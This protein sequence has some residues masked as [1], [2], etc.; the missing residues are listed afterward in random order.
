MLQYDSNSSFWEL[1]DYFVDLASLLDRGVSLSQGLE[2]LVGDSPS[3]QIE[4]LLGDLL[5][6]LKVSN[7]FSSALRNVIPSIPP[8]IIEILSKS[9]QQ[10]NLSQGLL[11][12]GHYMQHLR[13]LK[14]N[15]TAVFKSLIYPVIVTLFAIVVLTIL[16]LYVLP[17]V[18]AWF[19]EFNT[20]LP[21]VTQNLIA[22]SHLFTENGLI[23]IMMM[24]LT[25][26]IVK[27]VFLKFRLIRRVQANLLFIAPFHVR[28][29]RLIH[30]IK[31]LQT[32]R[33]FRAQGLSLNKVVPALESITDARFLK[34]ELSHVRTKVD[35]GMNLFDAFSNA[36]FYSK[37]ILKF[38]RIVELVGA[39]SNLLQFQ[40]ERSLNQLQG[41]PTVFEVLRPM[42]IVLLAILVGYIVIAMYQPLFQMGSVV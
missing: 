19:A 30:D 17:Q 36:R 18:E 14:P 41:M 10:N 21:V 11:R 3:S 5:L 4:K 6:E 37:R 16:M 38:V 13:S 23:W 28:R 35:A 25:Y 2:L 20:E 8:F 40:A 24:I 31:L 29:I 27:Y 26:L 12:V 33:L 1:G 7:V 9:E 34:D 39:D 15:E 22:F 32:L 42:L